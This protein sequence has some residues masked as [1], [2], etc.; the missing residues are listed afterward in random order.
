MGNYLITGVAGFI[1]SRTASILLEQGNS[2]VGID[3]LNDYYD[4]NLKQY[5][6]KTLNTYQ[7]FKFINGD[8]ENFEE[9]H[10]VF[11]QNHFDAVIN[12]AARAGVRYSLENPFV[13][14]TTNILGTLNLLELIKDY[15]IGKFVLASSSSVY[16]NESMPF[17]ED[18][19]VNRPISPYAV[20]KKSAEMFAYNY[21]YLYDIDVSILRFFTVYGPAGR[22]DMSYFRFIKQMDEHQPLIIFGDG[23]QARDFTYIDDIA[24]GVI[25][26]LKPVGCETF[27]LGGGNNPISI[28]YM[29]NRI[30]QGLG[31]KADIIYKEFNK[32]DMDKTWANIEKAKQILDWQPTVKFD[33]GINKTI[34]WYKN[35]RDF[36]KT[37]KL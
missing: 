9:L 11:N 26:S 29:I 12:L 35:N 3:N 30:E 22:P 4:V 24:A 7:A 1:A 17:V 16:A 25:A 27:N 32:T 33:Q 2:V 15:K 37:I 21:H 28:N 6:L 8:I 23:S 19:P 13:Y 36:V 18:L 34:E 31:K 14:L 5:R 20:T 10:N